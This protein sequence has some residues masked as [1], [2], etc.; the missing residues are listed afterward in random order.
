MN[1]VVSMQEKPW[2]PAHLS[3][4]SL[5]KES[6]ESIFSFTSSPSLPCLRPGIPY[7]I[8]S[9]AML[10]RI[11]SLLSDRGRCQNSQ[12]D[13]PSPPED[14]LL[15]DY[16]DRTLTLEGATD[17]VSFNSL[18]KDSMEVEELAFSTECEFRCT[19]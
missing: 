3:S 18:S 8:G 5:S 12:G 14:I 16:P 15:P 11:S 6:S 4:Q 17:P 2:T 19:D 13:S 1:F 7:V 9:T 10:Q